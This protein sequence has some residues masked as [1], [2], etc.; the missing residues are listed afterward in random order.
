[1]KYYE[2]KKEL[3]KDPPSDFYVF[4]HRKMG[5]FLTY[6]ILTIF[7]NIS[8]NLITII[9]LPL[10]VISFTTL[11]FGIIHNSILLIIIAFI[12]FIISGSLDCV[13]GN[14]ARIKRKTTILGVMLDRCVHNISHPILFILMGLAIAQTM[15]YSN[16]ILIIY[17]ITAIYSEFPPIE[18]AIQQ[19]VLSFLKQYLFKNTKNFS[20]EKHKVDDNKIKKEEK[21]LSKKFKNNFIKT[22]FAYE[23]IFIIIIFDYFFNKQKYYFSIVFI[24]LYLIAKIIKDIFYHEDISNYIVKLKS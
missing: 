19:V 8:P 20:L 9:L 1:M 3:K 16:I 17:I 11:Y 5:I 15:I 24:G 2:I 18:T 4:L 7:P 13:D 21:T 22:I 12:I 10:N 6:V 14:I 23:N